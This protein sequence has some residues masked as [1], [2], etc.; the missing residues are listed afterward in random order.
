MFGDSRVILCSFALLAV[1]FA[2]DAHG[3]EALQL[4][5]VAIL[6][7]SAALPF[8]VASY[9][10]VEA[11]SDGRY[12]VAPLFVAT[13]VAVFD[14]IGGFLRVIGR[15]GDGPGEFRSISELLVAPGDSVW[16]K[17]SRRMTL[18]DADLAYADQWP[19]PMNATDWALLPDGRMVFAGA[20]QGRRAFRAHIVDRD[21]R[22]VESF[23]ES[24]KPLT[25]F[26]ATAGVV[27]YSPSAGG[28]WYSPY[29][30]YAPQLYQDGRL[31]NT[32]DRDAEWFAP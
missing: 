21:G 14:S 27:S 15:S 32:V 26:L 29:S 9:S 10:S 8:E 23:A 12:L 4:E 22:V 18:L 25:N 17:Q 7:G 28:I 3:Q 11:L 5:R 16:V 30:T 13:E 6:G 20:G 19:M 24:P 31:T 1:P 2:G